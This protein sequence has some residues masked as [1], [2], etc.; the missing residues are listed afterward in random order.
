MMS[1]F[2]LSKDEIDAELSLELTVGGDEKRKHFAAA[3]DA[4]VNPVF[5][6]SLKFPLQKSSAASIAVDHVPSSPGCYFWRDG[7]GQILYIGKAIKLRSRVKSYLSLANG[8]KHSPRIQRMLQKARSVDIVLTPSE[9]DA[10]I[11]ESN[12]IKHHQPPYNVLLKGKYCIRVLDWFVLIFGS[13]SYLFF[14]FYR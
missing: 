12:L 9:R 11:L 2:D 1:I 13:S 8:T 5:Q 7:D 6:S 10:L 3:R 14:A 4:V